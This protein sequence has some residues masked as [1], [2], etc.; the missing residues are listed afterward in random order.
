MSV[1]IQEDEVFAVIGLTETSFV[2]SRIEISLHP[3]GN[4]VNG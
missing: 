4:L 3:Y 1:R 2:H